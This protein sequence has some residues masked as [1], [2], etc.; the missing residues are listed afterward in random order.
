MTGPGGSLTSRTFYFRAMLRIASEDVQV[1][2]QDNVSFYVHALQLLV[3]SDNF[4]GGTLV[5]PFGPSQYIVVTEQSSV[6]NIVLHAIYNLDCACYDPPDAD[7]ISAVHALQKYGIQPARLLGSTTALF[8]VIVSRLP[9][10]D[11]AATLSLYALAG[12]YDMRDLAVHCSQFLLPLR[13]YDISNELAVQMGVWYLKY[14]IFLRRG[15]VK[16]LQE[17]LS[18]LPQAHLPIPQCKPERQAALVRAWQLTGAYF[19]WH[20]GAG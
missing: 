11:V 3:E 5:Y 16:K 12:Q 6:F 18:R 20:G 10:R 13:T 7:I 15:R 9:D 19:I 4:F 8:Q 14:L 17:L 2:S 1:V